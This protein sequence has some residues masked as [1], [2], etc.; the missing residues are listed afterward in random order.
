MYHRGVFYL[1]IAVFF[2]SRAEKNNRK[3]PYFVTWGEKRRFYE[4]RTDKTGK[5]N[6]YLV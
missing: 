5:D 6:G 4:N 2:G 3:M 1:K